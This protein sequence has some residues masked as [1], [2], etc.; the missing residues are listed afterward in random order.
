[1]TDRELELIV[2]RRFGPDIVFVVALGRAWHRDGPDDWHEYSPPKPPI[3]PPDD[4]GE[5]LAA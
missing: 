2:G 1:M 3:G 5:R 4:D